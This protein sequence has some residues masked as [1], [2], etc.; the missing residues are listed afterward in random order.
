MWM[1]ACRWEVSANKV[2]MEMR[3]AVPTT[4]MRMG[5]AVPATKIKTRWD[6]GMLDRP[7]GEQV[8]VKVVVGWAGWKQE[9]HNSRLD[10][11]SIPIPGTSTR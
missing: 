3:E 1:W 6:R 5:E 2:G 4:G 11:R 10:S 8:V 9:A 7:F